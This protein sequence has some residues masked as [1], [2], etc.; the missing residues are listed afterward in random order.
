[1]KSLWE[2]DQERRRPEIVANGERIK[3][4]LRLSAIRLPAKM[5]LS[6][7]ISDLCLNGEY[8]DNVFQGEEITIVATEPP[9]CGDLGCHEATIWFTSEAFPGE[10]F[11][12]MSFCNG[13]PQNL[14]DLIEL[15]V[16]GEQLTPRP[17]A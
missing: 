15:Q 9:I 6:W 8:I 10:V 7:G 16:Y 3:A 13:A 14:I 12:A 2:Q 4:A 1:M 5:K 11:E 17:G